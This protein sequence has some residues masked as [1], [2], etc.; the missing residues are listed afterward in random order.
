MLCFIFLPRGGH[1][2]E[3]S[4]YK[5]F[6]IDSIMIG[7]QIHLGYLMMMHMIACYES[8]SCVLPY[9]HFLSRVFKDADIDLS[10]EKL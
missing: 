5:E 2:D 8:M 4:Y 10:R 1:Q 6:L 9:N 3:A 7:R